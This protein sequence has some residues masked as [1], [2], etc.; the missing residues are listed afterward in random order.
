MAQHVRNGG[1]PQLNGIAAASSA[2]VNVRGI[3][4]PRDL[5]QPSEDWH[6]WLS[7]SSVSRHE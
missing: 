7:P 6:S 5:F 3:S 4:S 2:V 1:S